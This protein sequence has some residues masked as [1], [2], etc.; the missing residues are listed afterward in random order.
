MR[1][2]YIDNIKRRIHLIIA[3]GGFN[4]GC[5]NPLFSFLEKF[6]KPSI[7]AIEEHTPSPLSDAVLELVTSNMEKIAFYLRICSQCKILS[8]AVLL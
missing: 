1:K 8:T 3:F 6:R 2:N 5:E 7:L 4:G